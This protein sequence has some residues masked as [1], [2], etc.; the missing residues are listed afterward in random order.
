MTKSELNAAFNLGLNKKELKAT[1][2]QIQAAYTKAYASKTT[3]K[4]FI[5]KRASIYMEIAAKAS[6]PV[7]KKK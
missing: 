3:D 1:E 5:A 7:A 4:D 6:K 2:K